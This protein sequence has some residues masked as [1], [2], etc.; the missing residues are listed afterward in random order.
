[1]SL[2]STFARS[3]RSAMRQPPLSMLLFHPDV[4]RSL[5]PL[6]GLHTLFGSGWELVH[7]FDR[8]HGTDTSGFIP[9]ER[10]MNHRFADAV[11]HFYCGSQPSIIRNALEQLPPLWGFTFVDLGAG[12]GRPAMVASEFPFEQVIGVELSPQLVDQA[13]RNVRVFR[14]RHPDHAPIRVDNMDAGAFHFPGGDLVLFLYNPFGEAVIRRVVANIEKLLVQPRSLFVIYYNPVY[15]ACF[16][17]SPLLTRY[18]AQMVPYAPHERGYGPDSADPVVIW[19][20]GSSLPAKPGAD[21]PIKVLTPHVRIELGA[22][23]R[24]M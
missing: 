9:P 15:G 21:A 16:D 1:M 20:G 12:K 13:R 6:P 10:L 11:P 8:I 22:V 23:P 2:K 4:R 5:K 17:A 7:P 18:Y 24:V 14:Q 3:M 19:Q